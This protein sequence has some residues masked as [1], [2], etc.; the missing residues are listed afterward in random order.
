MLNEN[1]WGIAMIISERIFDKLKRI[2]MTQKEFSDRTGIK[3]NTISE[4]KKRK[5]NPSSEKIIPICEVLRVTPEWLLTGAEP[6]GCRT[7]ES[8]YIVLG[9]NS[10][11]GK[12]LVEC[13][14]MDQSMLDR[15]LGYAEALNALGTEKN[16]EEAG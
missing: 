8:D 7:S 2:S 9:K 16:T 5:T 4:W 6:A 3:Q 12:I 10:G 1:K 13:S 15:I 11:L 14:K